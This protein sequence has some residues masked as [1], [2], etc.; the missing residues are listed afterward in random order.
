MSVIVLYIVIIHHSVQFSHDELKK[1]VWP[2]MLKFFLLASY[3]MECIHLPTFDEKTNIAVVSPS[4]LRE[5]T[6]DMD[7]ENVIYSMSVLFCI[8]SSSLY[9]LELRVIRYE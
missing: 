7:T 9:T 3:T 2:L 1:V 5:Y 4:C 8:L 6:E